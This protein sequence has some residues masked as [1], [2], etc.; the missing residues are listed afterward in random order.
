[1]KEI[2]FDKPKVIAIVGPTASGK[3][4]FAIELAKKLN[5]EII[6]A[7]SRLVYK[8]LDIGTAKPTWDEMDGI[9]HYMID[10][11]EPIE[12]YSAGL[13][14]ENAR[15]IIYDIISRA[16]TPIVAGGTGLYIDM[17]LKGFVLPGVEA[18]YDLRNKLNQMSC[19]EL[20]DNLKNRDLSASKIIEKNDRKKLIRALEIISQTG[21]PLEKSRSIGE[22]EFDVEWIGKNYPRNI[23]YERINERV[24][25]MMDMGLVEE[26]KSL[27]NKYGAIPN[28]V[29]TIGYKEISGYINGFYNLDEALELLKRNTRR[30]AKRQLTWFRKNPDIKWDIY[31]EKLSK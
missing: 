1:M 17:L 10:L 8:G 18:D 12:T 21:Q 31:P 2:L 27:L 15:K 22:K 7:D 30:Y 4:S 26:T 3:T 29:D 16:K 24:D 28:I 6:S 9:T 20:Y 13:Y 23:L 5:G 19:D 14:V 25:K 11:V